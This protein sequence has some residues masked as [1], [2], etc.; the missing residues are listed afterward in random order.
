MQILL[1][2]TDGRPIYEQISAQI[3]SQILDGTL[4]SGDQLPS[5][6]LLAKELRISVITTKRAYD[7][8]ERDGFVQSIPGKGSFVAQANRDTLLKERMQ[9]AQG[10]LQEAVSVAQS[11]GIPLQELQ[12]SLDEL[13]NKKSGGS[14]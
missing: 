10:H 5:I 1:S 7:D 14:K 4:Q 13:W 11:S 12:D 6:R 3:K 8:L 9:T 2:H